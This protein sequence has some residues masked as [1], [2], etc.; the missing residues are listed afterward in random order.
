MSSTTWTTFWRLPVAKLSSTR[1]SWPS[2]SSRS[3]M[4]EPMKPP[5]PVTRTFTARSLARRRRDL[6]GECFE[7]RSEMLGVPLRTAHR[8]PVDRLAHL[9][10][11][12]SAHGSLDRVEVETRRIPFEAGVRDEP[13]CMA[14]EIVHK[15]LVANLM[16]Q[17]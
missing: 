2:A 7:E 17:A 13:P 9:R 5:P 11:A 1:T 12:E 15:V 10:V 4:W 6:P 3:T 14:L 16:D 8:R